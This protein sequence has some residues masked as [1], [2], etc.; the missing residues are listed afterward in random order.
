[1]N[2]T[3]HHD[4]CDALVQL[5]TPFCEVIVHDLK[6]ET[7]VQVFGKHS[8]REIGEPS[9]LDD[10]EVDTWTEDIW[11]PYKKTEADGRA[12]KSISIKERDDTGEATYLI[13]INI[14]VSQFEA[15]RT[16]LSGLVAVPKEETNPLANDWLENLN[17]YVANWTLDRGIQLKDLHTS[18]RKQ[19]VQELEQNGLFLQ[20]NAAQ[21]IAKALGVS[22]ATIYQD[23]R[24]QA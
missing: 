22:R 2:Y 14:D 20:R 23:L 24:E 19:L 13:C 4:L 6:T 11:G 7:V 12:I 9:Y 5:L 8:T 3:A 1:M 17:R 10:M 16:L 15:A 18:D 21:A